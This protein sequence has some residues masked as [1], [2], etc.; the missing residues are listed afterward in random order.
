MEKN[1]YKEFVKKIEKINLS[2]ENKLEFLKNI[3]EVDSEEYDNL[4]YLHDAL[5]YL[6][7]DLN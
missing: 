6:L 7:E 3:D 4:Y 5:F 1:F 2:I